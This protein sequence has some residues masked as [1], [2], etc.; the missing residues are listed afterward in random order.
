[1]RM[2]ASPPARRYLRKIE[3]AFSNITVQGDR[4][5]AHLQARVGR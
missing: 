3:E 1:M 4:D 5:P 2:P